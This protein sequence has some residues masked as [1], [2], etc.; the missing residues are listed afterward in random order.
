MPLDEMHQQQ[1]KSLLASSIFQPL[2]LHSELLQ[3]NSIHVH[4]L[5]NQEMRQ[6]SVKFAL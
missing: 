4:R 3:I 1:D 5:R 2:F 6:I